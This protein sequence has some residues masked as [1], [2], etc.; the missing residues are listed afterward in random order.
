M[1]FYFTEKYPFY[2][3][4]IFSSDLTFILSLPLHKTKNAIIDRYLDK[5][6]VYWRKCFI[7][8]SISHTFGFAL[9]TRNLYCK[10]LHLHVKVISKKRKEKKKTK[11]WF[12]SSEP[13]PL[14]SK[15]CYS[16][17]LFCLELPPVRMWLYS[18]FCNKCWTLENLEELCHQ[19]KKR[20]RGGANII[21]CS[22]VIFLCLISHWKSEPTFF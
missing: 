9:L 8:E 12:F 10:K 3:T 2:L 21:I 6:I 19:R 20:E 14:I 22:D 13:N 18:I 17:L 5:V 15:W 7:R 16:F 4:I 11:A 1:H